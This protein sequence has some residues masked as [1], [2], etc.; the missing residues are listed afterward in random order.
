[1]V[2]IWCSKQWNELIGKKWPVQ[3]NLDSKIGLAHFGVETK[4]KT[5]HKTK[6]NLPNLADTPPQ[7]S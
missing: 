5:K 4:H 3:L 6:L 7:N 1:M 2:N